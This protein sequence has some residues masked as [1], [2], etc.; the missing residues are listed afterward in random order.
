MQQVA[1][2]L[3]NIWPKIASFYQKLLSNFD[4]LFGSLKRP[5]VVE[6]QQSC[7]LWQPCFWSWFRP[8]IL[9]RHQNFLSLISQGQNFPQYQSLPLDYGPIY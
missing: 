2:N 9:P 6:M 4:L 5:K 1:L 7:M 3:P 8:Q